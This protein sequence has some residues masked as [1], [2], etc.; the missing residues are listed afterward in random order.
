MSAPQETATARVARQAGPATNRQP[1]T[2][3]GQLALGVIHQEGTGTDGRSAG[4]PVEART[5]QL[6]PGAAHPTAAG[7]RTPTRP[8]APRAATT[9]GVGVRPRATPSGPASWS[10][11]PYARALRAG[12]GPLFLRRADGWLLP[13]DVER[14]CAEADA[15]DMEVLRR[16]EGTVLDVGCGPGRLVAALAR[17]GRRVLGID[18][19]EVAVACTL[20]AGG[21]ALRRSVFDSLPGEGRWGTALLIDGN[22]GIGGDPAALLD[23]MSQLLV[24]GGLLIAETVPDL[25]LDERVHVHVTDADGTTGTPF[26]WAR[27][28]NPALVRHAERADFGTVGQWVAGGRS[29]VALRSGGVGMR[30]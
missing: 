7:H 13:L 2:A 11:D 4:P 14:W 9:E 19:S 5:P 18:V 27:L 21:P 22:V 20:R 3:T 6:R 28:G 30:H 12:Q 8:E 26:L 23:R 15:M 29:F 1:V 24:P 17:Q 25:D 10:A 16:C